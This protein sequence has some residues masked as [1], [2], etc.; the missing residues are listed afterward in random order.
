[1]PPQSFASWQASLAGLEER[2]VADSAARDDD[3]A[4]EYDSGADIHA[5]FAIEAPINRRLV[6]AS[7][8]QPW[9]LE[10]DALVVS[11]NEGLRE[12]SGITGEVF[13]AAGPAFAADA[14]ALA[15]VRTGDA[16]LSSVESTRQPGSAIAVQRVVHAVGPKYQAQYAHAAAS[17]L[18]AAYRA[19]LTQCRVNGLRT[20]AFL[21][22]HDEQRKGYPTLDACHVA[23][24]TVRRF[25]E[26][27]TPAVDC[28]LLLLP[29]LPH[30]EAYHALAPLYFPR[31]KAELRR[32]AAEFKGVEL[33][34]E[35]GEVVPPERRIRINSR[36]PPVS[37]GAAPGGGGDGSSGSGGGGGGGG[38]GGDAAA[39]EAAVAHPP[40]GGPRAAASPAARPASSPGFSTV[41]LSPA[42]TPLLSSSAGGSAGGSCGGA[43]SSSRRNSAEGGGDGDEAEEA[44]G[45]VA[46]ELRKGSVRERQEFISTFTAVRPSPDERRALQR[47]ASGEGAGGSA[48]EGG[49]GAAGWVSTTGGG[50]PAGGCVGIDPRR[51]P[52]QPPQRPHDPLRQPAFGAPA[53][54]S[55]PPAA[56]ADYL[57]RPG[58][59]PPL[60]PPGP[61][62]VVATGGV[63]RANGHHYGVGHDPRLG[64][65]GGNNGGGGGNGGNSGGRGKPWWQAW[66]DEWMDS[67]GGEL[68]YEDEEEEESELEAAQRRAEEAAKRRA[69]GRMVGGPPVG[70]PRPRGPSGGGQPGVLGLPPP[71]RGGPPPDGRDDLGERGAEA[72]YRGSDGREAGQWEEPPAEM[73]SDEEEEAEARALYSRMLTHASGADLSGIAACE[74]LY[75][76]GTDRHGR[77]S[78][79]LVGSRLH[80]AIGD[81][82]AAVRE[83][84]A[85]LLVKETREAMGQPFVLVFLASNLPN[86]CGPTFDFLRMLLLSLPM[87]IHKR[88]RGFYLVHPSLKM[89]FT[90]T[91]LG[92]AL[93]GKLHFIDE[94]KQLREAFPPG[95][96]VVPNFVWEADE[97][98]LALRRG[99]L[100]A[101]GLPPPPVQQRPQQQQQRQQLQQRQPQPQPHLQSHQQH[102]H[103]S[104]LQ[105][106]GQDQPAL[107]NGAHALEH[108]NGPRVTLPPASGAP[109]G[110]AQPCG[111]SLVTPTQVSLTASPGAQAVG[112]S[113]EAEASFAAAQYADHEERRG[114]G[115]VGSELHVRDA[116][117]LPRSASGDDGS[118]GLGPPPQV[119]VP[120]FVTA[121]LSVDEFDEEEFSQE[122]RER[123]PL[124]APGTAV[125]KEPEVVD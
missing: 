116:G 107:A 125:A 67:L 31:T 109:P 25:L 102:S 41:A 21:P 106:R 18:H 15:V 40:S 73:D 50:M 29:T 85:L 26:R 17:A 81:S 6:L 13:A 39:A 98:N 47:R 78:I 23:L 1:M 119:P 99:V 69:S 49:S 68:V 35:N 51:G 112:A 14:N 59:P 79:V 19:A 77:P 28:V 93:W 86:D 62:A 97:D 7:V 91:V 120:T 22:L 100:G 114:G 105:H 34:D 16:K 44:D 52:P 95:N 12:R 38:G 115:D 74:L 30:A 104:Q 82:S 42:D 53:T 3:D 54:H 92:A 48:V 110:C 56:V 76:S 89:R 11:N 103:H 83:A 37:P 90:F 57:P 108:S 10:V 58:A 36:L 45:W 9:L 121:Q 70:R 71:S 118:M 2:A 4:D 20:I 117:R 33:G 5:P 46:S 122:D 24:R 64:G 75:E 111:A 61:G 88:L 8:E 87:A 101:P 94:L 55:R 84:V 124:W 113:S 43:S 123:P 72:A 96:L 66:W 63:H 32:S 65:S 60:P 80:A 27:H